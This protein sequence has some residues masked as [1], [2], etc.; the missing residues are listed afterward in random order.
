MFGCRGT[1]QRHK[2]GWLAGWTSMEL[3]VL[4]DPMLSFDTDV[5]FNEDINITLYQRINHE[6]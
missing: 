1:F 3:S 4:I 5:Y 6:F 2:H